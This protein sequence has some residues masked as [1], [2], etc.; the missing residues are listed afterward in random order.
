MSVVIELP[1]ALSTVQD[2]GRFRFQKDGITTSGV[3]DRE[4]YERANYLVGNKKGEAVLELTLF[5]GAM[6]FTEETI[7][8]ITG[9]DMNPCL[10]GIE[11]PMYQPVVAPVKS[12]LSFGFAEKGCRTYIAFAGGV[13]VPLKLGSRSTNLKCSL[14]GYQGR[15]LMAGDRLKIGKSEVAYRDLRNRKMPIAQYDHEWEVHVIMGPQAECFTKESRDTFLKSPYTVGESSDR[16]GY[17][18]DGPV[19]K[20]RKGT[21]IISEGIAL[22]SIQI[23][24]NGQPIILM[25]DHQTVGGYAKIA[26]VCSFDL[27]KVAQARPG[28]KLRFQAID[29]VKAQKIGQKEMKKWTTV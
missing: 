23:P 26:C 21:D 12:H 1:G 2:R 24:A 3:M 19:I 22:G 7:I 10:D 15:A 27:P 18:L 17:R 8:A 13:D 9:A 29:V 25:A 11:I 5:G 28:D 20:S 4:A 16:M 14:G 6:Q